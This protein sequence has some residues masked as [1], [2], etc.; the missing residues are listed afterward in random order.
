LQ[1]DAHRPGRKPTI[2]SRSTKRFVTLTT[3]QQPANATHWSTRTMAAV[4][5]SEASV[6]RIWRAHGLKPHRVETFEIGNDAA[7][8]EKPEDI[9]RSVSPSA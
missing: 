3:R 6:R 8:V 9:C 7:I 5:I 4:G 2:G 1:K